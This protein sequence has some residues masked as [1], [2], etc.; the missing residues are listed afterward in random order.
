MDDGVRCLNPKLCAE[1]RGELEATRALLA[2]TQSQLR[3]FITDFCAL[4]DAL[5]RE[6]V[7]RLLSHR[8]TEGERIISMAT[9]DD[10]TRVRIAKLLVPHAYETDAQGRPRCHCGGNWV[11]TFDDHLADVLVAAGVGFS[12]GTPAADEQDQTHD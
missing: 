4:R 11:G 2:E 7:E 8:T 10:T 12:T 9:N 1:L 6:Q 3:E 5:P